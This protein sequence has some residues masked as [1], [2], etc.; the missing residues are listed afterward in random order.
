MPRYFFNV[1]FGT[2]TIR[3]DEGIDLLDIAAA[4]KEAAA[5]L[6]EMATDVLTRRRLAIDIL[7]EDRKPIRR[8]ILSIEPLDHP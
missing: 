2:N 8:I 6:T 7:E 5:S 4:E 3:D 1:Y